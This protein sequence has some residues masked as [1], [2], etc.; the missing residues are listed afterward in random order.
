MGGSL[1]K[2]RRCGQSRAANGRGAAMNIWS[3]SWGRM[4]ARSLAIEGRKA[5]GAWPSTTW[6]PAFDQASVL[7]PS[8]GTLPCSALPCAALPIFC[9]PSP[10]LLRLPS[11]PGALAGTAQ[12]APDITRRR[13]LF[14]SLVPASPRVS[15]IERVGVPVYH[16]TTSRAR[17]ARMRR[18]ERLA[19]ET[20]LFR[21]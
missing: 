2:T 3:S 6:I 18:G 7:D 9:Q 16:Q 17:T 8:P 5:T 15:Q 20:F 1:E 11:I 19:Q 21:P 13:Q 4:A 12:L 14:L 10:D